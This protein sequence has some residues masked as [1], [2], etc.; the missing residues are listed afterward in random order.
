MFIDRLELMNN[1]YQITNAL[2]IGTIVNGTAYS[3]V[4]RKVLGQGTFGITYLAS[5]KMSGALGTLDTEVLV[6]IK[7]FFMKEINGREDSTVTSSSKDGAFGYYKSKF[8]HEAENLSRL[9]HPNIIKVVELFEEN[10]TAYYAMEY[11]E[12]GSLDDLIVNFNGL[13]ELEC[14]KYSCQIGRALEYMHS[15]NMLH[16]DLKPNNIMLHKNGQIVLIDFG[17]AKQFGEDGKPETSTTIGHGTPGYAPIEQANYQD[18]QKKGFPATMDIYAFGATMFKMLT[19]QR[20][21]DASTVLNEGFPT[22]ELDAMNT[23]KGLTQVIRTCME[24][25]CKNRY[26]TTRS[27]ID[28]LLSLSLANEDEGTEFDEVGYYKKGSGDR[29]YGTYKVDLIPVSS[30]F[31][32]PQSIKIRLWDNSKMGKS[33]ELYLTDVFPLDGDISLQNSIIVWNKGAIVY[34]DGWHSGIPSDVK[35]YIIKHGLL[36]TEHWENEEITTPIDDNFG[37]DVAIEMH[38]DEGNTFIRRVRYAHKEWHSFLLETIEGLLKTPTL[39]SI[40]NEMNKR[41][42]RSNLKIFKMPDDVQSMWVRYQPPMY[43]R[44]HE[45]AAKQSFV[46]MLRKKGTEQSKLSNYTA[47]DNFKQIVSEFDKLQL[48]IGD[49]IKDKHD[50]SEEPGEL[51]IRIESKNKGLICLSLMAFNTDIQAGNIYEANISSLA[52][53]INQILKNSIP[54]NLEPTRELIY[55]IPESTSEIHISYSSGGAVGMEK[56]YKVGIGCTLNPT[57]SLSDRYIS[58]KKE[59]TNLAEGLR[60]LKLKSKDLQPIEPPTGITFPTLSVSLYDKHG[61]FIKKFYAQDQDLQRIGDVDIPVEKLK[62]EIAKLCPSF[63]KVLNSD[64]TEISKSEECTFDIVFRFVLFSIVIGIIA[65]P[66]YFFVKPSDDFYYWLWSSI[67]VTELFFAI[68]FSIGGKFNKSQGISN[69]ETIN[70]IIGI[71]GLIAYL[72]LWILQMCYWWL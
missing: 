45:H 71:L 41:K 28:D 11:V 58:N 49:T 32:F 65:L 56:T 67:G 35:E 63:R 10:N 39:S 17:L 4:I 23:S 27:V 3:Y 46:Y 33:Y 59:L 54:R 9:K 25:L 66:T 44:F 5:V 57:S 29:G 37:T 72:I 36:S 55:S 7:E 31:K 62:D 2:S 51:E 18:N 64:Q 68:L 16:L 47:I 24:P 61:N 22:S 13:S 12:G 43:G 20:P 70:F 52:E 1:K 48:K 38:D 53:S 60:R 40:I 26:K 42:V 69:F 14:I 34:E 15:Q 19:G 50:Y 30:S 6:A 21:P 8:I